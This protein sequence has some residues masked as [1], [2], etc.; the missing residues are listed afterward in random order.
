VRIANLHES[1]AREV[2]VAHALRS[3]EI[4]YLPDL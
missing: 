3:P 2:A 1:A 4:D